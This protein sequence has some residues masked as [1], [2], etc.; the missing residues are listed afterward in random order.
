MSAFHQDILQLKNDEKLRKGPCELFNALMVN[1]IYVLNIVLELLKRFHSAPK[2]MSIS[3]AS[4]FVTHCSGSVECLVSLL[5]GIKEDTPTKKL[6]TEAVA[7]LVAVMNIYMD[8]GEMAKE[9][10]SNLLTDSARTF[11]KEKL[12]KKGSLEAKLMETTF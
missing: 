12:F 4:D 6:C 8:L 11:L 2:C 1:E 9:G 3:N 7:K 5:S 10:R